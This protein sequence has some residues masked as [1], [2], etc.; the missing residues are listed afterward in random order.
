MFLQ[1]ILFR[2]EIQ[3]TASLQMFWRVYF[4]L[5]YSKVVCRQVLRPHGDTNYPAV[6]VVCSFL[7][8][9][10]EYTTV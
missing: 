8:S 5:L 3:S 2:I 4:I 1:I 10:Y 9:I 7:N 6:P